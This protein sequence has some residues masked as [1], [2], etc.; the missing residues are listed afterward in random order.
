M[1]GR[2]G[3]EPATNW[4]KVGQS[5]FNQ[6]FLFNFFG[7]ARCK[8]HR[9]AQQSTTDSG[10]SPAV[11]STHRAEGHRMNPADAPKTAVSMFALETSRADSEAS[12]CFS[13]AMTLWPGWSN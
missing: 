8:L 5:I 4:L 6:L 12:T 11:I 7:D 10:K 2:A 9:N 13:S 3:F 1:V